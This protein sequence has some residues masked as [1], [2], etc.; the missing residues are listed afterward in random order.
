MD[1]LGRLAGGVAHDFNNLLTV[2]RGY[3]DVL[4]TR[5]AEEDPRLA[6]VREIR[7]AADRA[8][9]LTRQLLAVS[10]RQ[11]LVPR[12]VDLNQLMQEM[13]R[14]LGR[15]IGEHISMITVPGRDLGWVRADP[16]QLEQ[17]LLN[18]AVNA[19]DAMPQGGTLTL[20]T[21]RR[22]LVPGREDPTARGVP[23]GDYV[24]LSVQDT[25]VGMDR[26]TQSMIFEPFFT[27][28]PVGEG[29]GLGLSTVYGIVQQSN[30]VITV[31]SEP[32]HGTVIR[33]FLPRI[34]ES[35]APA[36]EPA[37]PRPTP[38]GSSRKANVLVVEDDEGVRRLT[39]RVLEQYGYRAVEARTGAEALELLNRDQPRIDAVVSD[40]VMPGM[41]G[42][43]LVSRMRRLRPDLPVVF[44][45]GYTGDEISEEIRAHP[46]QTFLQK[47]FSPDALVAALEEMIAEN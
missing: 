15:V 27:T 7:S 10:R 3:A 25:G 32:G 44:L 14:M 9:S 28:K 23:P 36:R 35:A 38:P 43:E 24:S 31:E 42:R 22:L 40:V 4:A 8:T 1:S 41:G 11:V 16:S 12:E 18:L 33:I 37:L 13:E 5:F 21:R 46:R 47:P 17:V 6:E 45:S 34:A 19:R 39:R 26:A 30:G 20:E 2:I 29:T